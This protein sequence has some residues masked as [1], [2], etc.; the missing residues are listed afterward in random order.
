G[1]LLDRAGRVVGVNTM[2]VGT[3]AS[4]GFAVAADHVKHLMD[5]PA[6]AGAAADGSGSALIAAAQAPRAT[7]ADD[8]HA[9]AVAAYESQLLALRPRADQ[10]DDYWDRFRKACNA[11]AIP[12]SGDRAWFGI[13]ARRPDMT[14]AIPDCGVWLADVL[15]LATGV[16]TALTAAGEGARRGGVYPGEARDLRRKYR[17]GWDG[18]DR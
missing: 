5:N 9:K 4:I 14:A 13:W 16:R 18:W 8:P 11:A 12:A 10:I 1:P 6:S 2:K 15:Q 17:L 7:A 3:A